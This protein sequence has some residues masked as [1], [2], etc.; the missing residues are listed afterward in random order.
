VPTLAVAAPAAGITAVMEH[1]SESLTGARE[2]GGDN[3]DA[4]VAR[5]LGLAERVTA[6]TVSVAL[7]LPPEVDEG[8]EA[9]GKFFGSLPGGGV[10]TGA[11]LATSGLAW[12]AGDGPPQEIGVVEL[13][14]TPAGLVAGQVAQDRLSHEAGL[15][16]FVLVPAGRVVLAVAGDG[17]SH[18]PALD[19]RLA[20]LWKGACRPATAAEAMAAA[21]RLLSLLYGD[22]AQATA[23]AAAAV[24]LPVVPTDSQLLGTEARE[25]TAVL[26][27]LPAWE[28]VPR[29][30]RGR[31]PQIVAPPP[32]KSGVRKSTS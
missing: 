10:R 29:F 11:T 24:F 2:P 6:E 28:K 21:R 5:A 7:A 12:K 20:T 8:A 26:A 19:A 31:A 9:A 18:V 3:L 15:R 1:V 14:A 4:E 27:G 22:A 32:R 16:T 23:R 13:P 30:A 17:G 25:V